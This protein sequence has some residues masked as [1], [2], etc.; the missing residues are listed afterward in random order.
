MTEK[1]TPIEQRLLDELL[2]YHAARSRGEII[3]TAS[4][5]EL[6]RFRQPLRR[7]HAAQNLVMF[8]AIL[9]IGVVLLVRAVGAGTGPA[10]AATPPP[11]HYT[12]AGADAPSAHALLLQ[13][14]ATAARQPIRTPASAGPYA[15]VKTVGWYLTLGQGP[16]V[17]HVFPQTTQSW[18][19]PNGS[20]RVI[21]TTGSG[22]DRSVDDM[23]VRSGPRLFK[24]STDP[25]RLARQLAVGHPQ[26]DGPQERLVA[27][28]DT[29]SQ[30]PI[31]PAAE[32]AIL[33][34]I[35]DTP[36]LV[37]RGTVTDREGRPGVALS[38][39]APALR[40]AYTLILSPRT[41]QLLDFEQTA[42]GTTANRHVRPG[43]VVAYTI[44]ID[45]GY[46]TTT[47]QTPP[48]TALD[49]SAASPSQP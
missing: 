4:H 36:H 15:Y 30:Q 37:N 44:I 14:A 9:V 2:E 20:G 27:F 17:G 38:L 5:A 18:L 1:L 34:L 24:L 7:S 28:T 26:S 45:A 39:A 31:P 43:A 11:L 8:A 48:S 13:L 10:L 22:S 46:T 35:A 3:A 19:R 23:R 25:S 42:I 40:N 29:A 41:G 49:R 12:P 32:A 6:P 16:G 33:R 47:T 21:N